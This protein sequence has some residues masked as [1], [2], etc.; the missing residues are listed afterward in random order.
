[1]PDPHETL[2]LP[3]DAGPEAVRE[4]YLELV[5]AHPPE[6]HPRRFA[7]IRAAYE[8]ARDPRAALE[9]RLFT[10]ESHESIRAIGDEIRA[11]LL[12]ERLPTD[13]LLDLDERLP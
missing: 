11:G 6:Q 4:R 9:R 7:E 3:R 13:L 2:G 10:A 1:M 8:E 5:R 12:R